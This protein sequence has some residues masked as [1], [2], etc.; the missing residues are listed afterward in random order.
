MVSDSWVYR[1]T[2]LNSSGFE[3][4]VASEE[5]KTIEIA[6]APSGFAQRRAL[7][8]ADQLGKAPIPARALGYHT[9]EEVGAFMEVSARECPEDTEGL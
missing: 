9:G 3:A 6:T 4:Y 5:D 2:W 8:Q 1:S 7:L